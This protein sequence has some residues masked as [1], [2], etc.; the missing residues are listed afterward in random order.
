MWLVVEEILAWLMMT[1]I[2]GLARPHQ[3]RLIITFMDLT[4]R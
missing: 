4:Y 1:A 2:L 3:K